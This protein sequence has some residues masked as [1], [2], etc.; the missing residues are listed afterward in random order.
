MKINNDSQGEQKTLE[1]IEAM[2]RRKG[3]GGSEI[4]KEV[5]RI[6]EL[7]QERMLDEV[8]AA[9]PTE[10]L[11]ELENELQEE[12]FSEEMFEKIVMEANIKPESVAG[13]VLKEFRKEYLGDEAEADDLEK[14]ESEEE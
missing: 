11:K 7:L 13:K 9:L 4:G 1:A 14:Q 12:E 3:V 8:L 5:Q 10:R 2:A 6:Y